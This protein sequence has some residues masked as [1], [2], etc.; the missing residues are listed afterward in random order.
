MTNGSTIASDIAIIATIA[1]LIQQAVQLGPTII[2]DVEDATPFAQLI[3]GLFT[4]TNV[5]QAMLDN[6][7]NQLAA[8]STQL[9]HALPPDD[10][11]TTT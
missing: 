5:T 3:W 4:G 10:G 1:G 9:Q 8:L 7:E 11:T 2:A 6:L